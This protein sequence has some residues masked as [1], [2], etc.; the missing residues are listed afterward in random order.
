MK[1]KFLQTFFLISCLTFLFNTA[2][3]QNQGFK[4]GLN[5]F[6]ER[7]NND[8]TSLEEK[9]FSI[10][11]LNRKF[12]IESPAQSTAVTSRLKAIGLEKHDGV[13]FIPNDSLRFY[14][15]GNNH[16][17]G[18]EFFLLDLM[19]YY[20][21]NE[22]VFELN[23]ELNHYFT[24]SLEIYNWDTGAET[25]KAS[26]KLVTSYDS[27]G[28]LSVDNLFITLNGVDWQ[29]MSR[30]L[31][32][33]D[34][35]GNLTSRLTQNWSGTIWVNSSK[36]DYSY[37]SQSNMTE[38]AKYTWHNSS[39]SWTNSSKQIATYEGTKIS[40]IIYQNA[41]ASGWQNDKRHSMIYSGDKVSEFYEDKWYNSTWNKEEKEVFTYNSSNQLTNHRFLYWDGSDY[42][43]SARRILEYEGDKNTKSINQGWTGNS[44]EYH[45][46]ESYTYEG[47][48]LIESKIAEHDGVQ[49]YEIL[50]ANYSYNSHSQP[51]YATAEDFNGT[52]WIPSTYHNTVHFYYEDFSPTGISSV[53]KNNLEIYPNPTSDFIRV[54]LNDSNLNRIKIIDITGKVVFETKSIPHASEVEIPVNHLPSGVYVLRLE[55]GNES[56]SKTFVVRH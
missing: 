44:W 50:K 19:L 47:N 29:T 51:I 13:M 39:S 31:Y 3:A 49:S 55:N 54:K 24:D 17:P 1:I 30:N 15:S 32:T 11:S 4:E 48:N 10:N 43:N 6:H 38:V 28:N 40:S 8:F 34:N 52:S 35:N 27:N 33:Y 41:T 7:V 25:R 12:P 21:N 22:P 36:I 23:S 16:F 18:V 26:I 45:W 2:T 37:D 56:G 53:E 14:Y 42:V 20:P 9:I 5:P 46:I